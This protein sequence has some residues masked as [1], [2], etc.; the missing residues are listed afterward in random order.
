MKNITLFFILCAVAVFSPGCFSYPSKK[1]D[2]H[3][4]LMGNIRFDDPVVL[5]RAA[6][7]TVRLLDVTS[8]GAP[9]V[10]LA[11][12]SRSNPGGSPI[13]FVLPYPFGG[14]TASRRY[15][16]E[17]RIQVEGRL[18]Y[19]SMEAHVVTPLNAVKPHEITL[20]QAKAD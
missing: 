3:P 8:E 20:K 9:A 10:V 1:R 11:E 18:R 19:F 6:M 17:A 13:A 12:R 5:P 16:I 7:L 2:I 4:T 15:V 14:I